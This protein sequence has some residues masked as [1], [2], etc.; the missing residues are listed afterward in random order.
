MAEITTIL[1]KITENAEK[2][3]TL[4]AD[5]NAKMAELEELKKSLEEAE[6]KI[7]E[8]IEAIEAHIAILYARLGEQLVDE[9]GNPQTVTAAIKE[10]EDAIDALESVSMA[11]DDELKSEIE[12]LRADLKALEDSANEKD[13][14]IEQLAVALLGAGT[15]LSFGAVYF[16]FG[17]R[18]FP[19]DTRRSYQHVYIKDGVSKVRHTKSQHKK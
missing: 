4:I 16:I 14:T 17:N 1:E 11:R 19:V 15:A 13:D 5:L 3:E 18:F 12:Q 2:L 10:L 8:A 7:M 6:A 9:N